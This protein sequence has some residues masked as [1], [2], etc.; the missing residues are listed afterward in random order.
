MKT[1]KLLGLLLSA[2]VLAGCAGMGGKSDTAPAA[3]QGAAAAPSG[4][5]A[6]TQNVK[7]ALAA[8]PETAGANVSVDTTQGKVRLK[9]EV[10]SV[11]AFLK[12]PGIVKKV[13][14][15]VE[16]DNQLIVCT[17]CK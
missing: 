2:A 14:G 6:I 17:T 9:G 11:A 8:D 16:V 13:P 7:N 15:V 12:A 5:A 4:D 3:G 10:K 1:T